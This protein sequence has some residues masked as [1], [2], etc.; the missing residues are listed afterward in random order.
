M[1]TRL[2]GVNLLGVFI[3]F[4]SFPSSAS[5]GSP[6]LPP[7]PP[8]S[9]PSYPSSPS[10]STQSVRGTSPPLSPSRGRRAPGDF[11]QSSLRSTVAASQSPSLIGYGHQWEWQAPHLA[12]LQ[13]HGVVQHD[14]VAF[15]QNYASLQEQFEFLHQQ[16]G[17]LQRDHA[18]LQEQYKAFQQYHATLEKHLQDRTKFHESERTTL[19]LEITS[20]NQQVKDAQETSQS[21]IEKLTR[22]KSDLREQLRKVQQEIKDLQIFY[23]SQDRL[24][25]LNF[26][27]GGHQSSIE[28]LL[29]D[30]DKFSPLEKENDELKQSYAVLQLETEND[31]LKQ[32][33]AVLQ[34]KAQAVQ[35]QN[36]GLQERVADLE[37]ELQKARALL[38]ERGQTSEVR[39]A[40]SLFS[41]SARGSTSKSEWSGKQ[42]EEHVLETVL[43][44]SPLKNIIEK[45]IGKTSI[46]MVDY[47]N[48]HLINFSKMVTCQTRESKM[49]KSSIYY[50]FNQLFEKK[51][52]NLTGELKLEL[53]T[54]SFIY[55]AFVLFEKVGSNSAEFN[56]ELSDAITVIQKGCPQNNPQLI[57][58]LREF[59]ELVEASTQ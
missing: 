28:S 45:F 38:E 17:A 50:T 23:E 49:K 16:H 53:K 52:C 20:L 30:H 51:A 8:Q 40:L 55:W 44:K 42:E 33:Y 22:E 59:K 46:T 29:V 18:I 27:E 58:A 11:S 31:E 48:D 47:Y 39:A 57:K 24:A 3:M 35:V 15:Q 13:Q 14:Q 4:P 6:S 7:S 41:L 25:D 21:A 43:D 10:S 1:L 54:R 37:N 26:Q 56:S 19:Q 32:S 36:V 5:P 34:K 2:Y 12:F 9:N